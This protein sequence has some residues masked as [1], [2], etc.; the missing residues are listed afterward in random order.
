MCYGSCPYQGSFSGECNNP[1]RNSKKPDA[2]CFDGFVCE[3]CEE[4]CNESD[5]METEKSE[6]TICLD[7]QEKYSL[8][9]CKVCGYIAEKEE[10]NE[11]S[12]CPDCG[13]NM[14]KR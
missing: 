13:E 1:T 3:Y 9:E 8:T 10:M 12:E 4:I 14:F 5:M 6:Q 11:F 2:H 7:C